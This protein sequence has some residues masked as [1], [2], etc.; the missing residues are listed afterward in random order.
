MTPTL[1]GVDKNAVVVEKPQRIFFLPETPIAI[2]GS[3]GGDQPCPLKVA[4]WPGSDGRFATEPV[5][6]PESVRSKMHFS[7]SSLCQNPLSFVGG[8]VEHL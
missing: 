1:P 6:K 5:Q 2:N 8:G 7:R 4:S 3:F